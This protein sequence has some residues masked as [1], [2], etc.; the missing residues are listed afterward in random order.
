[1]GTDWLEPSKNEILIP[2]TWTPVKY[3]PNAEIGVVK[4]KVTEPP[5]KLAHWLPPNVML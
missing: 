5:Y 1:M 4:V 3:A 2:G